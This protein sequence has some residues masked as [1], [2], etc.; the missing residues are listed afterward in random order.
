MLQEPLDFTVA[1]CSRKSSQRGAFFFQHLHEL[2]YYYTTVIKY[3]KT[4]F[5]FFVGFIYLSIRRQ[6]FPL[7]LRKLD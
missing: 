6:Q 4:V 5:Y 2:R 7:Y 3:D 1:R